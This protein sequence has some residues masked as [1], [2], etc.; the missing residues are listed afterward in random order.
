[1]SNQ[2]GQY[3]TVPRTQQGPASSQHSYQQPGGSAQLNSWLSQPQS[4]GAYHN[5]GSY[6][7]FA[8]PGGVANTWGAAPSSS[9]ATHGSGQGRRS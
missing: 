8:T 1:M 6:R 2:N 7:P 3:Y 4:S 9:G 5:I